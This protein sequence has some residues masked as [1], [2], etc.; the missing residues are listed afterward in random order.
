MRTM[1]HFNEVE[2]LPVVTVRK[3]ETCVLLH[4]EGRNTECV[5]VFFKDIGHLYHTIFDVMERADELEAAT[6]P[7]RTVGEL[8]RSITDPQTGEPE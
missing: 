3:Q 2:N 5:D 7:V 4:L 8:L 6:N 1:I